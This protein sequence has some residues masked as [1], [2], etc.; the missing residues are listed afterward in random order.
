MRFLVVRK[1]LGTMLMLLSAN[2]LPPM[3]IAWWLADGEAVHFLVSMLIMFGA[4]LAFRLPTRK[5]QL[6]LHTRDGF[7]IVTLFWIAIGALSSLP[8]ILGAHLSFTD[9]VFESIS[10]FTTTGATVMTG[11]DDLPRS[12]LFYRQQL[13]WLGGMGIIVL[14]VAILPVLGIGGMQL[15]RAETPGPIKDDKLTPR[16]TES[17]RALWLIY[18]ALTLACALGYRLAGMNSFDAVAHALSTLSTGGFSTHDASLAF[19]DNVAIEV[20]AEIFMI[21]AAINFSVH[22]LAIA[23][24]DPRVYTRDFEA[25]AFLLL[26]LATIIVTTITLWFN[27]YYPGFWTALRQ[28]AFQVV[29]VITST[30]YTTTNFSLWPLFLPVLLIFISFVGGCAGSTA[31]GMKVIRFVLVYKQAVQHVRQL[32]H[33]RALLPVKLGRRVVS[34]RIA[35]AIWGF[36]GVYLFTF[37][38]IMLMVMATGVDQVT[39]FSAVAT[40]MNNLGPGLGEV[41]SNFTALNSPAKWMLAAAMLLG[42]LEIFT[43]IVVLSP[44]YW[45]S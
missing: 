7:L 13:Q 35:A 38:L 19:F 34:D 18:L 9:A 5:A 43:V 26:I 29:S 22:F 28:S 23:K 44:D 20:V 24:R 32:I 30:G 8:F 42:R 15:Y 25:R 27:G 39:A 33:T 4:G 40:S 1:V 14:A 12:I 21:L 11:L 10:A 31:G 16:I 37:G 6:D 41:S 45:R 3:A 36:F 2:M 17:A